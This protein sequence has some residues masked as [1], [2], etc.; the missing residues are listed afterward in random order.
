MF[1]WPDLQPLPPRVDVIVELGGL[2]DRDD[3]ALGLARAHRGPVLIQSTVIEEAGT[4][5][6]LPPVPGVRILCF[7]PDPDTTRG[8]AEYIGQL[9]AQHHWRSVALVTTPDQAWRARLRMTRC[10]GGDVYVS[11][12]PLPVLAWFWQIPYQWVATAKALAFERS[13]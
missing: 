7:H 10:F 1:I 5:R 12:T 3:A 4:E 13:C 2:G 8:E 11:T 9:A 6:C